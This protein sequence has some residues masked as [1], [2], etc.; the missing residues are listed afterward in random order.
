MQEALARDRL[1]VLRRLLGLKVYEAKKNYELLLQYEK[2]HEYFTSIGNNKLE[3]MDITRFDKL[4]KDQ[5]WE[6]WC[7][8][9]R[10]S[11]LFLT[12]YN[13]DSGFSQCWLSPAAIHLVK[14]MHNRQPSD[15]DVYAF[16]V[17]GIQSHEHNDEHL[18]QVLAHILVQ[19]LSQ[20]LRALQNGD[21]WDDLQIAFEQYATVVAAS[22]AD[23]KTTFR[24]PQNMKVVQTAALKVL[25]LFNQENTDKQKTVWIIIDRLD[26]VK[27]PPARLLEVL[28]YLIENAEVIVKILTVVNGLDWPNL[29]A[30]IPSL[31]AKRD[32]GVIVYTLHQ[33]RREASY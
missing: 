17:L 13:N 12:G 22:M 19:L 28:E 9:S 24:N 1:S 11:L 15:T 2:D 31:E 3:T 23:P 33:M 6:D 5:G 26:R 4:K 18:T 20:Q 14:T 32:E 25:N 21:I 27:E 29:R 10:S 16:Y 8:S 30:L 7:S